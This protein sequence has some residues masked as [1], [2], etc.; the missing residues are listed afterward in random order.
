MTKIA[1][2]GRILPRSGLH[3]PHGRSWSGRPLRLD[4]VVDARDPRRRP[5]GPGRRSCGGARRTSASPSSSCSTYGAAVE[6]RRARR[7]GRPRPGSS[8]KHH[9]IGWVT[10][11]T[12][13]P[14]GRSTRATSRI[15]AAESDTNGTAPYAEQARSKLPSANG[16]R[17]ASAWTSGVADA[18]ARVER[19]GRARAARRTGRSPTGSAP[20][21]DQPA[22]ALRRAGADLEHPRARDVAEQVGLGLAEPLGAPQEVGVAEEAAVLGLILGRRAP[23]TTRREAR[24]VSLGRRTA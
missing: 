1:V 9:R 24:T 18:G 21:V 3:W 22:A 4:D 2:P 7:P 5:R 6:V 15:T 16:S 11:N 19:R 14:P 20:C 12:Q 23:P 13:R 10:E 17:W 8:G